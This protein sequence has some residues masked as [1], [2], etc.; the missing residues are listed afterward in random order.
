[1]GPPLTRRLLRAPATLRDAAW[2]IRALRRLRRAL[3]RDGLE[4]RVAAPPGS[5]RAGVRGVEL[6]LRLGHATCLER[7]LI[8]QRWLLAHGRSHDVLVGVAGG[9]DALD[10]HAWVHRY[11]APD[12]ADGYRVLTRVSPRR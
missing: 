8:V 2:A 1:M 10:A 6:A 7:S 9:V 5:A 4:A 3:P 11:D 12:Q